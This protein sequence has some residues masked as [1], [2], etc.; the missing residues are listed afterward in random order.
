MYIDKL[1]VIVKKYNKT[2]RSTIKMKPINLKSST[3]FDFNKENNKE[4]PK[5]E[6]G[7][8]VRISKYKNIFT[9]GCI[10]NCSEEYFVIKK[11]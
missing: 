11:N 9:K 8:H 6:A 3:Y 1:D 4:D 5:F 2:Y 10:L 7:D